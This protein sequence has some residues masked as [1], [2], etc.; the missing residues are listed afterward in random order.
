MVLPILGH[1]GGEA[2]HHKGGGDG[3]EAQAQVQLWDGL[4]GANYGKT[5]HYQQ[6]APEI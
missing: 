2:G 3:I 5:G 6:Q 1:Q 4:T